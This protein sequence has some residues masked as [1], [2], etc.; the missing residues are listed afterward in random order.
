[1]NLFSIDELKGD[2]V[3]SSIFYPA[4]SIEDYTYKSEPLSSLNINS[5]YDAM[6]DLNDNFKR[7]YF[8]RTSFF[9][10]KI[11]SIQIIDIPFIY[12]YLEAQA[13]IKEINKVPPSHEEQIARAKQQI[14]RARRSTTPIKT[15]EAGYYKRKYRNS[16]NSRNSKKN[17]RR[18]HTL[19]QPKRKSHRKTRRYY[20]VR[21]HIGG[22]PND[23]SDEAIIAMGVVAVIIV[24][25]YVCYDLGAV[26]IIRRRLQRL[27]PMRVLRDRQFRQNAQLELA[28]QQRDIYNGDECEICLESMTI[29]TE[30]ATSRCF[31]VF[32]RVC[33]MR[34]IRTSNT[35]PVCRREVNNDTITTV[36]LRP[37]PIIPAP[38]SSQPTTPVPVSSRPI[39]PVP[40]SSPPITPV[41]ESSPPPPLPPPPS[42]PLPVSSQS[43]HNQAADIELGIN[44][45]STTNPLSSTTTPYTPTTGPSDSVS[46][47]LL[48]RVFGVFQQ[49][50]T[51]SVLNTIANYANRVSLANFKQK[52][53]KYFEF[54]NL[55]D[56]EYTT[57]LESFKKINTDNGLKEF[58]TLLGRKFGFNCNE[59]V[60]PTTDEYDR[61]LVEVFGSK[62]ERIIINKVQNCN[63]GAK[64]KLKINQDTDAN[65]IINILSITLINYMNDPDLK[66]NKEDLRTNLQMATDTLNAYK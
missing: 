52:M 48:Q 7:N 56:Q 38:V 34:W 58:I 10:D 42:T 18:R 61:I 11:I 63:S 8:K 39:I 62:A 15:R 9:T 30:N 22:A 26:D 40:V 20:N 35:C 29:Y 19:K 28:A 21:Q 12:N 33:I 4:H 24:Y 43:T 54:L 55:T 14:A 59:S 50:G 16:R 2:D 5:I 57:I 45:G 44:R 6:T 23:I 1:M 60:K 32:H 49:G 64:L 51:V 66:Q 46:P 37:R 13:K 36:T 27:N 25:S 47:N 53:A 65:H 31:H 17:I 41:P 3:N